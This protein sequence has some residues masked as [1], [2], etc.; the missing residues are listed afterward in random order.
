MNKKKSS[1]VDPFVTV[2]IFGVA[3]DKEKKSTKVVENNGKKD[4]LYI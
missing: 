3:R 4:L 1:I 2:E